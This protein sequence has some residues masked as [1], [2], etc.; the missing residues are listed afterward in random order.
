MLQYPCPS[1]IGLKAS[2][3]RDE[4]LRA[5]LGSIHPQLVT[6]HRILN[7]VLRSRSYA[8]FLSQILIIILVRIVNKYIGE[9]IDMFMAYIAVRVS[10]MYKYSKL[11]KLYMLSKYVQLALCQSYLNKVVYTIFLR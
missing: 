9:V 5:L 2:V 3:M 11:N 6:L 1:D 8:V 4:C 7:N 10:Q